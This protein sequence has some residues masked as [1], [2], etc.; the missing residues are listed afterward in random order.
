MPTEFVVA[1]GIA[2][3]VWLAVTVP[4]AITLGRVLAQRGRQVPLGPPRRPAG[5]IAAPG[6]EEVHLHVD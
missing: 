2:A 4:A 1:V 6:E 5:P 3:L